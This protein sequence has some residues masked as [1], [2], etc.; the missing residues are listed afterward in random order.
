M[1]NKKGWIKYTLLIVRMSI[2]RQ[3]PEEQSKETVFLRI[4]IVSLK[5]SK[6]QE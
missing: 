5:E 2:T 4:V 1:Q 6:M 3:V